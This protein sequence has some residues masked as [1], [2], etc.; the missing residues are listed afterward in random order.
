MAEQPFDRMISANKDSRIAAHMSSSLKE[1][2]LIQLIFNHVI[3]EAAAAKKRYIKI[4][5]LKTLDKFS[6]K[7]LWWSLVLIKLWNEGLYVTIVVLYHGFMFGFCP[8][9]S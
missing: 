7:H 6:R 8:K 2:I 9:F 3:S 4:A 1:N 5:V